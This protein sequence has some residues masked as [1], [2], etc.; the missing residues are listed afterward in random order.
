MTEFKYDI[1]LA[2]YVATVRA[3]NGGNDMLDS[4]SGFGPD[5]IRE[6]KRLAGAGRN[7]MTCQNVKV[8]GDPERVGRLKSHY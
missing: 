5:E 6:I 4:Y 7:P 1:L 2:R 8:G 3:R